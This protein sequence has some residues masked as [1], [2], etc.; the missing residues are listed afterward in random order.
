[1]I[2]ADS[3]RGLSW[4]GE[5]GATQNMIERLGNVLYWAACLAALG[6]LLIAFAGISTMPKPEWS[7][8][9]IIGVG[10]SAAI[11]AA[12]RAVR[13]VLAGR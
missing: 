5:I 7:M 4:S 13:Y 2:G 6:W 12:G 11:W 10:I 3:L 8:F 9:W 1:M